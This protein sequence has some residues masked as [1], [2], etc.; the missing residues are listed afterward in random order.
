MTLDFCTMDSPV[1]P[2]RLIAHR[3]ALV[4]CEFVSAPDRL[5]HALA[6]LHKHL[7]NCE[8][9]EHHDP[10]GSVGRLTRYFAGEL[11]AIDDQPCK[12]FGTE[13]QLSVWEALRLIPA[14]QTWTYAQLATHLG[15]PA[16]MRAVG[17]AN[18]ANSIALFLP[19]HRVIAAD[20]TLWG[21]GGGLD[22]KRW[23][24]THEGAAFADKHSQGVLEL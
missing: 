10:A 19:C 17:A 9:R 5:E 7:G 3:E 13:F 11:R 20:H 23:L 21:Y 22:R 4:A 15:K 14:G 16:A 6:R 12:P 2:L 24:L 1:G 8:P 18:G